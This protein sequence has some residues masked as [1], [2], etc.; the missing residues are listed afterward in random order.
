MI[1]NHPKH[2]NHLEL[3]LLK[4]YRQYDIITT[5]RALGV[6]ASS[7]KTGDVVECY[8]NNKKGRYSRIRRLYLILS[9][10]QD[11]RKACYKIPRTNTPI[12]F[13]NKD[14]YLRVGDNIHI[15][16]H[17]IDK[18]ICHAKANGGDKGCKGQ[19]TVTQTELIT[20]HRT[21]FTAPRIPMCHMLTSL[22]SAGLSLLQSASFSFLVVHKDVT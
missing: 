17:G 1:E 8:F 22:K 9:V 16:S 13:C 11:Y 19:L 14:T 10:F 12:T 2:Y 7:L 15:V 20:E 18:V 6:A 3:L 5:A 4:F 21:D